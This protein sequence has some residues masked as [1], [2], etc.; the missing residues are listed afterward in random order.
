MKRNGFTLVE[1]MITVAVVAILAM[2]AIPSYTQYIR[3]GNRTDAT[4]TLTLDAQALERCYSQTFSYAPCAGVPVAGVP[5]ASVE[6]KYTVT[7]SIPD[8]SA[9]AP[10]P[11]A[12]SYLIS[13]VPLAPSQVADTACALFTLNTSNTQYAQ[14]SAAAANTQ[15]CWGST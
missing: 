7:I 1:L 6:G 3:R 4:K 8:T 2:I 12:P 5:T 15:T 10:A 14:T 9:G 13:A 11:P